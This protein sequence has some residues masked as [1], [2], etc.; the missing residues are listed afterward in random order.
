[1]FIEPEEVL[2]LNNELREWQSRERREINRI[3]QDITAQIRMQTGIEELPV[4]ISEI[5]FI[6]SKARFAIRTASILPDF[7]NKPIVDWID[8][9]HPLLFLSFKQQEKKVVDQSFQLD[10]H[11][12][13]ILVSGPNAGG[14][15]VCLKT[16]GLIQYMIQCG[17]E[18]PVAENSRFGIFEKLFID[19]GDEQSLENDLSTYSSHLLNMKWFMHNASERT[20]VLIDEFGTGTDPDYGGA[21]AEAV[22]KHLLLTKCKGMITTHY[23]NL[24][25]FAE[26]YEGIVNGAM[27]FDAAKLE[28]KYK[29]VVGKP[30]SS[31]AL[32]IAKKIGLEE[33]I[34][35]T[36]KE[37]IGTEKVQLDELIS[38]LEKEKQSLREEL[39]T[40]NQ[41]NQRL[42]DDIEK[43]RELKE[44]IEE[45]E[46]EMINKAK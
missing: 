6:R 23:G 7:V 3:L 38:S 31:F 22:L 46:A 12:R 20:L 4:F 45:R 40:S 24:K 8:A 44:K 32:E 33:E 42:K 15:S 19:I 21:I 39:D 11:Q 2:E 43:Y 10:D 17:L 34:L 26:H 16:L 9:R 1:L 25:Q 30:G 13:L 27:Q 18:V 35:K 5:D 37:I 41:L 14:K 29:L 36:A 28:P